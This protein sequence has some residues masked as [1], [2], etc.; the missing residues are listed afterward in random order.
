MTAADLDR[1]IADHARFPDVLR[2]LVPFDDPGLLRER[3]IDGRWSPLEILAHLEEEER[4]DFRVRARL[5]AEGG[6]FEESHRI[7]PPGWV[8]EHRYNEQ[9]PRKVIEAFARE[10]AASA[11]WLETLDVAALSRT[12]DIPGLGTFRCGDFV[13]AWREHDL[14]TLRQLSTALAILT[15]RRLGE[16]KVEYSGTIPAPPSQAPG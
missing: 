1:L 12:V 15:A 16:W 14:L 5:A 11:A 2:A 6:R 10:R 3:E 4:R 7:D 9:D 8:T 13:A